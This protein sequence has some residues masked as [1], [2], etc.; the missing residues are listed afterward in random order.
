MASV[1]AMPIKCHEPT[2]MALARSVS[3]G[4]YSAVEHAVSSVVDL[5]WKLNTLVVGPRRRDHASPHADWFK[6]C[7]EFTCLHVIS[8]CALM[9]RMDLPVHFI[10][11]K[12]AFAVQR[13]SHATT[14]CATGGLRRFAP[15]KGELF[16]HTNYP[17]GGQVPQGC[18][19]FEG[20]PV[21]VC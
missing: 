11:R 10:A 16:P 4:L 2:V 13:D 5:P 15:G 17:V 12:I 8:D 14:F 18:S 6:T 21:P 1:G 3:S 19:P 9:L 20:Q 7:L